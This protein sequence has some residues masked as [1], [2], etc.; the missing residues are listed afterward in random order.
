MVPLTVVCEFEPHHE[1]YLVPVLRFYPSQQAEQ[2]QLAAVEVVDL[3]PV[4]DRAL[5]R[6]IVDYQQTPPQEDGFHFVL[7]HLP[8][9]HDAP[10]FQVVRDFVPGAVVPQESTP[11]VEVAYGPIVRAQHAPPEGPRPPE[12]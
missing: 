11:P 8:L 7:V 4:V 5:A 9:V 10:P 12:V 6:L 2:P 3:E 1:G